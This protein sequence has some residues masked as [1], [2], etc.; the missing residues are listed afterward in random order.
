M[1]ITWQIYACIGILG[2]CI[3]R[4]GSH[5]PSGLNWTHYPF[6]TSRIHGFHRLAPSSSLLSLFLLNFPAADGGARDD[7]WKKQT[8]GLDVGVR[9]LSCAPD[10]A[11][12][13]SVLHTGNLTRRQQ[14]SLSL[15]LS[16]SLSL[17]LSLTLSLSPP[18]QSSKRIN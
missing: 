8:H 9:R 14:S 17:S 1:A 6:C 4:P 15:S 5:A 7:D 13:H 2:L 16:H 3:C 10:M 11:A 18:H 12:S